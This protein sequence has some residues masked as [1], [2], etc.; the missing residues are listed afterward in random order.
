M[1]A[2]NI[3]P[4]NFFS[5]VPC[6]ATAG[7]DRRRMADP[8]RMAVPPQSVAKV[9][10][11]RPNFRGAPFLA[12]NR[13]GNAVNRRGNPN[14]FGT[15]CRTALAC[16]GR[17]YFWGGLQPSQ[18]PAQRLGVAHLPG[19]PAAVVTLARSTW[20]WRDDVMP[21]AVGLP[22]C[23]RDAA[24][25]IMVKS[26]HREFGTVTALLHSDVSSRRTGPMLHQIG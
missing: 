12:T 20:R 2:K 11:E 9:L 13:R 1:R 15:V 22:V 16:L 7:G 10:K 18:P 26:R 19:T 24:H 14:S 5:G 4:P 25:L 23:A 6:V 3:K 8:L 21:S 17:R